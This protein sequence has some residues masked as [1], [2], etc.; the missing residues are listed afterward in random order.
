MAWIPAVVLSAAPLERFEA[1]EPHM[2]TLVQIRLYAR[3]SVLAQRAFESA[4][5]R[6]R[7]LDEKLSDYRPESELMR[8]CRSEPGV[9]VSVSEDLWRVLEQAQEISRATDGMFDVSVGPLVSLWREARKAKQLPEPGKLEEARARSGYQNLHLDARRKTV[10]LRRKGMQLD[11]GGIAKGY[12]ASE[13]VRLLHRMG[14]S[15]SLVAVSGDIALGDPPPDREGWIV[16]AGGAAHTL[17]NLA[18][19]TSGDTEQFVEIDGARYSHI[20]DPATG[21]GLRNS[22]EV[23]IAAPHG[24]IADALAT[25]CSVG[26]CSPDLLARFRARQLSPGVGTSNPVGGRY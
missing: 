21:L 1:V 15:R 6:L 25:A 8:L 3:N 7:E 10:T 17:R 18:I 2:G 19:S 14:I 13:A 9:A 12:A 5:R 11:L 22:R 26:A 4:F 24:A 23:S 20:V 16:Q